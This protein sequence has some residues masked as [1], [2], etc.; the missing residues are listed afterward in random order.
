MSATGT[1]GCTSGTRKGCGASLKPGS[2]GGERGAP[3]PPSGNQKYS[4]MLVPCPY[5]R[6]VRMAVTCQHQQGIPV[7]RKRWGA[8]RLQQFASRRISQRD[9]I[10]L[11][12]LWP[13]SASPPTNQNKIP[14]TPQ[15]R[16]K[17]MFRSKKQRLPCAPRVQRRCMGNVPVEDGHAQSHP[18][19]GNPMDR[20]AHQAPLS[21]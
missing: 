13:C 7:T 10:W 9:A 18:T 17:K 20:V 5:Q 2:D 15:A 12:L 1:R 6:E 11:L 3:P 21:T 19:L 8:R 16:D 4:S 14:K